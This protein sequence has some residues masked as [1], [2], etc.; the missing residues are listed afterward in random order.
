MSRSYKDNHGSKHDA[1][2]RK[3]S[4]R[5]ERMLEREFETR[6]KL[7][8]EAPMEYDVE[9]REPMWGS[10]WTGY[11]RPLRRWLNSHVGEPW[12]QV[13]SEITTKLDACHPNADKVAIR[14]YILR[15]VDLTVNPNHNSWYR[16]AAD[17]TT[18]YNQ[19]DF[20]VDDNGILQKRKYISTKRERTPKYNTSDIA[21]WLNGR[22]IGWQGNQ[23]FWFVPVIKGR[24][25]RSGY[26]EE[27]KCEWESH[28]H[29][30]YG[31]NGLHYFYR[32]YKNIY[33]ENQKFVERIL[34]WKRTISNY[35]NARQDKPFTKEEAAFW[36]RLP[37][38][39]Q[40]KILEYSPTNPNPPQSFRW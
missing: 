7:D 22:L 33:D 14:K 4:A 25:G 1:F 21:K 3:M 10:N 27:W 18:S 16:L 8:P 29:Y 39:Y 24:R 40:D 30:H 6:A 32:D 31:N 37:K 23:L 13:Y 5:R 2:E 11:W 9:P 38:Y 20:Y 36:K 26:S 19:W 28:T 12:N 35:I 15:C 34:I 17:P